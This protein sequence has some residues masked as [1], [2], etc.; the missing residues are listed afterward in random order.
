MIVALQ[1]RF[2]LREPD[3]LELHDRG[4]RDL[5]RRGLGR[6]VLE[7]PPAAQRR[8]DRV[9]DERAVA[10]AEVAVVAEEAAH[11]R[12]GGRA[13]GQD[14]GERLDDRIELRAG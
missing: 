10:L 13:R 6:E 14:Q 8:I 12:V 5:A 7:Q 2:D 4:E 1:H 9:G 11:L 3:A